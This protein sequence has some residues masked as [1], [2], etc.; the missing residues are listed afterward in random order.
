MFPIKNNFNKE[1][2]LM[3]SVFYIALDYDIRRVQVIQEGFKLNCTHRLL[4]YA[5]IN[6]L[7]GSVHTIRKRKNLLFAIKD[8]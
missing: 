8:I 1:E 6:I 2:V 3:P 4:F 5:Y 7:G